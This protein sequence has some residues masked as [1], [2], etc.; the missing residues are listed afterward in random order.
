LKL[1]ELCP[2]TISQVPADWLIS[3]R[4]PFAVIAPRRNSGS[5]FAVA[6]NSTTPSPWP[7]APV[8]IVSH[9]PSTDADHAHSRAAVTATEALPPSAGN[10][11]SIPFME[12]AQRFIEVG[13]VMLV[14]AEPPHEDAALE[15]VI[16][17]AANARRS[18]GIRLR[19]AAV[20]MSRNGP[21]RAELQCDTV[22]NPAN[23]SGPSNT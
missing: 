17:A 4:W 2:T 7:F 18:R 1:T 10:G 19:T 23:G 8:L 5:G 15:T 12:M 14:E 16:T 9:V 3:D 6:L 21:A 22:K 20:R 11:P 13:A